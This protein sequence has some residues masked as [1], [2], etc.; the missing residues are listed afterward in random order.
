MR[1][2]FHENLEAEFGP[3][4]IEVI[5]AEGLVTGTLILVS[6]RRHGIELRMVSTGECFIKSQAETVEMCRPDWEDVMG[7]C[8][9]LVQQ[10]NAA[11]P[12][13]AEGIKEEI[14]PT[15]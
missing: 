12:T 7:T 6:I 14:I 15:L 3:S 4:D 11:I 5:E 1:N 13:S 8:R 2:E 9:R 10:Q